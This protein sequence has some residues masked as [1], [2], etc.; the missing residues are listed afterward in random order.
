M[1]LAEEVGCEPTDGRPSPVFKSGNKHRNIN[2][3]CYFCLR[4]IAEL[5]PKKAILRTGA[6]AG[7]EGDLQSDGG[8]R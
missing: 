8:I 5:Q 4:I 6:N 2:R 3:L 7:C 1:R